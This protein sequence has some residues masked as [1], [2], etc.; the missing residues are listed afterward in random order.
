[1]RPR[2][3]GRPLGRALTIRQGVGSEL[4][5]RPDPA[6]GTVDVG[7]RVELVEVRDS[8]PP[9]RSAM[10]L[11][12]GA[13]GMSSS[14]A[15]GP[16]ARAAAYWASTRP[17]VRVL[18]LEQ[19]EL[20]HANGASAD[21]SR[22][23]RLSYHR[24]D[25]VRLAKRA[26]ATWA[27]VEAEAGER[28]V[29]DDRRPRPVAGRREH[30]AG[31]TTSTASTAE[32]VPFEQLDAAEI[33]RRWPQ[34]RLDDEHH[35][36]CGRRRVASPTRTGATPRTGGWRR[37]AARRCATHA[38]RRASATGPAARTRS[39]TRRHDLRAGHVVLA[40]DAWTNE[41]LASFERR[42]PL[43]IT[44]E[45]VTYFA[46]P[47]PG[48]VRAGPVPGL[49]LDGRAVLLRL[50]D[51][52]RGRPEGGPGLSAGEATTARRRGPSSA[53]RGAFARV[54]A[55]LAPICPARSGRT[56]TRRPAC[57]RSPRTGTS[58]STACPRPRTCSW[59]SAPPMPSSSPRCSAASWPSS[60]STARPRRRPSI[61]GFRIDR[62][63]L[64][65]DDPPTSFMV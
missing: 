42:L 64:L 32:G 16:S 24:P 11:R 55:F 12:S 43:T 65:L 13:T 47:R 59:P 51:L 22:I 26:Y 56:C 9:G 53:T 36:D 34:W 18:G 35:G 25:Y 57:T 48:G 60:S 28:I 45:Q 10:T 21:H 1:M 46:C 4:H 27:E 17:G 39:T 8:V 40:A 20:G 6:A 52:R 58:S 50:P 2:R 54:D 44:K 23:I 5:V 3:H 15:S 41:L 61:A 14:S 49:D 62:P 7:G 37:T 19:F 29:T 31:P 38:G 33:M 63:I 30:P